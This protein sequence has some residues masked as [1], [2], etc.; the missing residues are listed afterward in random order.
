M[1]AR[2]L[3]LAALA[4]VSLL[5]TDGASAAIA[6]QTPY[7]VF[8]IPQFTDLASVPC[9]NGFVVGYTVHLPS[10][11]PNWSTPTPP[12]LGQMQHRGHRSTNPLR[13]LEKRLRDRLPRW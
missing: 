6:C 9:T 1:K 7:G 10:A 8:L 5:K 4:V 11:L 2:F 3:A 12:L 13:R